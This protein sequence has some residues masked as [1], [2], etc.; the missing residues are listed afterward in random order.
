VRRL[1]FDHHG[2]T[3]GGVAT[4]ACRLRLAV[5][6]FD[7]QKAGKGKHA[8]ALLA[9]VAADEISDFIEDRGNLL[10]RQ[11]RRVSDRLEHR[12]LRYRLGSFFLGL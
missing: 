11:P 5:H 3:G 12:I 6:P 4:L 9:D 1:G 10:A 2:L 7:L 8:R